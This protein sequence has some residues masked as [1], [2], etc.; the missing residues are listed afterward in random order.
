V[1]AWREVDVKHGLADGGALVRYRWGLA[2]PHGRIVFEP[3]TRWIYSNEAFEPIGDWRAPDAA[4][5]FV[6]RSVYERIALSL[7]TIGPEWTEHE[8]E[9]QTVQNDPTVAYRVEQQQGRVRVRLEAR[10]GRVIIEE[11]CGRYW[12]PIFNPR[13]A[14]AVLDRLIRGAS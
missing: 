9:V 10:V 11:P 5:P 7:G 3:T 8:Y 12:T 1:N 13:L 2:Y 14:C 6:L 4:D